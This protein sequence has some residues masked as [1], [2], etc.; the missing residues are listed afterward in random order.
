ML[1]NAKWIT[2]PRDMGTAAT[3]FSFSYSPKKEIKKATLY[4]SAI[5]LDTF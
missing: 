3:T 2:A 4:A 5:G 1:T